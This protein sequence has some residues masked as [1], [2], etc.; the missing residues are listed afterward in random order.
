MCRSREEQGG[1][2]IKTALEKSLSGL[3][4][5]FGRNAVEKKI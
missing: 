3:D 4:C 2:S 1:K 5:A